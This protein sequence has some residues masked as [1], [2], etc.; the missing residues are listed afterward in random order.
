VR[1]PACAVLLVFPLAAQVTS[2]RIRH[3][4]REPGNWLTYSGSYQGHRHSPLDQIN[5]TNVARLKPVWLYQIN[6]VN[7]FET[8]PLAVDGILY[9]SEP[10]SNATA[11]DGRTGRPLWTYRRTIPPDVHVCCGQVNRGLAIL[12]DTLFLGTIDA[13]L[14]ALDARTGRVRWDAVVADYQTGHSITVAPLVVKDKVIVGISG[15]EYGIRGF[16]D[17]YDAETGKRVWRFWTV[18]G[19]GEPGHETWAGESWK[20][21]GAP[22]WVTGSYDP[23]LNL[24]Y[25]GTG[26]PGPDY[27]GEPREGNNLYAN[28]LL[29]IEPDTGRLKWHFQF[30]PHDVHDWDSNHVPVLADA[31]VRGR[32]RKVVAMANRNSFYYLLDRATGEFLTGTPYA[33]QTWAAGLDDRGR[34]ILLP[35]KAPSAEGT[36]VYPGLHGGTN[37]FSPSYSPETGLFYVA[38]REEATS[39]YVGVPEYHPGGFFS[40]GGFRG[41]PGLEPW[42]AVR[43]LELGTGKKVWEFPLHSPPWAGLLSTAGGLVFGGT[44]EGYFVALGA[45]TGQPLW[46]FAAGGPVQSNPISFLYGGKQFVAVAAGHALFVFGE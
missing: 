40:A 37:W 22:T 35:G 41:I 29:A 30:T 12:G 44:S 9:I 4:E 16:L 23:E 8:T 10:P 15:G 18:P 20:T 7:Q 1:V 38:A 17:A 33:Q 28:S 5:T 13:H 19:P 42:G 32:E 39:F 25:W 43:A 34:P 36:M 27:N 21:G 2:E 3:A 11:L 46:R 6:D 14:V 24:V 31:S 45:T 26:N